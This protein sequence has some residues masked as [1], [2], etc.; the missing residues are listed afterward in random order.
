MDPFLLAQGST[1]ENSVGVLQT[2]IQGGVPLILAVF[3]A[4]EGW[5]IYQLYKKV[6]TLEEDYRSSL[7]GQISSSSEATKELTTA[8]T[9]ATASNE[10]VEGNMKRC[11]DTMTRLN[12]ELD[13]RERD[14]NGGP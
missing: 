6:G 1:A 14:R 13:K 9:K 4:I 11:H 2:I 12:A 10:R 3:C 5:V 7:Q 8:L